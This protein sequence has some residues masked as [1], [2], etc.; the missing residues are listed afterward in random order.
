MDR[1]NMVEDKDLDRCTCYNNG[2]KPALLTDW[3]KTNI[4]Q[5]CGKEHELRRH[6]SAMVE[7]KDLDCLDRKMAT[8]VMGWEKPKKGRYWADADG[9]YV[10]YMQRDATMGLIWEPTRSISQ[11]YELE[12]KVMEMGLESL[13]GL[14]LSYIVLNKMFPMNYTELVKTAHASPEQ[15]CRAIERVMEEQDG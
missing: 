12:D 10:G 11:A 13:Y 15:R 6:I 2:N 4:C 3:R 5:S 7:D 8:K 14:K 9:E 1:R